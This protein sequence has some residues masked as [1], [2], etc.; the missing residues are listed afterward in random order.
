MGEGKSSVIVPSV[1]AALG[2]GSKLIRVIV[3][4]PQAKQLHQMLTSKLSGLLDR[5]V[6]QLPFSRDI[7]MNKSRAEAIHQLISE[8]MQEGGVLLVQPE[9]L[10][11]FQLMELECQLDNKSSV[12]EKMMEVRKFFDT[13]SRDVVDESDE[14]FSV[15]FELIYTV[16]QQR[17]IDHSPDRWRVIQEILGLIARF[18]A[19]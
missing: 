9:H 2:D 3:A 17:P 15:K 5:P 18:S 13:S 19:E 8:C 14:N 11:S 16:G 7:R 1:A 10:L 6:Y 4:K 12:A